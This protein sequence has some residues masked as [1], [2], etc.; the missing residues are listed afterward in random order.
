MDENVDEVMKDRKR[1]SEKDVSDSH[2]L[3]ILPLFEVGV[4]DK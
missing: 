1:A 2:L 4:K 3:S